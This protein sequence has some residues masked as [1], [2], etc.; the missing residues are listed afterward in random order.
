[1]Q[2]VWVVLTNV[3]FSFGVSCFLVGILPS[4]GFGFWVAYVSALEIYLIFVIVFKDK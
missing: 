3:Q 4:F 1:M 2:G